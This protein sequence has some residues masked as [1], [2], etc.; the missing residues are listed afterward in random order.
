M[1]D[2]ISRQDAIKALADYEELANRNKEDS[3]DEGYRDGMYDA[4]SIIEELPSAERTGK[5]ITKPNIYGAAYCSE[6]DFELRTND[7]NYCPDCG[8]RMVRCE[9]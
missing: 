2:S 8:A 9:L 1:S 7:T 6:C 3:Y 5:W 4:V